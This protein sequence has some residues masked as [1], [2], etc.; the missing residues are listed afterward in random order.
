MKLLCTFE[1]FMQAFIE[2]LTS[3]KL[4]GQSQWD[5]TDVTQD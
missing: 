5:E 3:Q 1:M 4:L 2:T